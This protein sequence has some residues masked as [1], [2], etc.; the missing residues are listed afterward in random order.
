MELPR[1]PDAAPFNLEVPLEGRAWCPRCDRLT[2]HT[3]S[4][5]EFL[6]NPVKITFFCIECGGRVASQAADRATARRLAA[7]ARWLRL[8]VAGSFLL[9]L[10]LPV[11]LLA[12]VVFLVWRLL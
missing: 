6:G 4:K 5:I 7:S 11:L 3:L 8:G 12:L 9:M 10:A 1:V 2:G